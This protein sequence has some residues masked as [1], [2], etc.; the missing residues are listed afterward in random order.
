MG[1]ADRSENH[2][3]DAEWVSA[4]S[5]L[6]YSCQHFSSCVHSGEIPHTH[7]ITYSCILWYLEN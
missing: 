1:A 3:D 7:M 6:T 5:T 2:L 4:E